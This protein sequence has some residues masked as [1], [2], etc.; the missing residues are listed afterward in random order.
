MS[1]KFT[2]DRRTMLQGGAAV[3]GGAALS[4]SPLASAFADKFPS[5]NLSV[6]VATREGGGADRNLRAFWSV[7]KKYLKTDMEASFYPG[8]AG[9]V[10]YQKYM[11]I[12]I[13]H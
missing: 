4:A 8:A 5:R 9:R 6:M 13:M 2:L 12:A 10:G 1:E 7:W 3:V 11:G